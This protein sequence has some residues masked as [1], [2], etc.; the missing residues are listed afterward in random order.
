MEYCDCGMPAG[1]ESATLSDICCCAAAGPNENAANARMAADAFS[2]FFLMNIFPPV[3][4]DRQLILLLLRFKMSGH[5]HA[6]AKIGAG[7]RE[8]RYEVGF[9][10]AP[11]LVLFVRRDE[12]HVVSL[13][14]VV[15]GADPDIHSAG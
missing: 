10:A 1:R 9:L 8:H 2:Q 13:A 15:L 14:G 12:H 3:A 5:A 4:L 11:V 7:R 6:L